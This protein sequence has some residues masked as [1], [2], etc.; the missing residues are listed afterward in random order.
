MHVPLGTSDKEECISLITLTKNG[1][2]DVPKLPPQINAVVQNR[3]RY[4]RSAKVIV[5][6]SHNL[7]IQINDGPCIV[8]TLQRSSSDK[9]Y[10]LR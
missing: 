3:R 2:G 5:N 4:K 6:Q 7:P 8:I 10:D 9:Y 1:G